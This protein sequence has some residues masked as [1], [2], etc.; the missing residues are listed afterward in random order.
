LPSVVTVLWATTVAQSAS[1]TCHFVIMYTLKM[2]LT[3]PPIAA[4]TM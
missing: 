2:R 4:T 3:S 1:I